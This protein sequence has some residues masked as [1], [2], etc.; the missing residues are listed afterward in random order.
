MDSSTLECYKCA[1]PNTD[2]E[3]LS[4]LCTH[5]EADADLNVTFE[6]DDC[7]GTSYNAEPSIGTN[8]KY[9]VCYNQP[10]AQPTMVKPSKWN[11]PDDDVDTFN[12]DAPENNT[13]LLY[14]KDFEHG[15]YRI[16]TPGT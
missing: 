5:M 2:D 4:G 15:T 14:N 1:A 3:L 11:I 16:K 13:I 6:H 8:G 12:N 10:L 7:V 9:C